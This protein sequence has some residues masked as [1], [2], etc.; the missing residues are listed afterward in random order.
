[1]G[2]EPGSPA[3]NSP[4]WVKSDMSPNLNGQASVAPVLSP[5]HYS[6]ENSLPPQ[7]MPLVREGSTFPLSNFLSAET[8]ITISPESESED[9]HNA[10]AQTENL[11]RD[12]YPMNAPIPQSLE[13]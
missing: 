2:H 7:G 10:A 13:K 11:K 9:A 1:L 3:L 6:I 4:S 5:M 8:H 12:G